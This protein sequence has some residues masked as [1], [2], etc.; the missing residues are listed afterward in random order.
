M[1]ED[2]K[3]LLSMD[4]APSEAERQNDVWDD[5]N[6]CNYSSDGSK[7]LE[8]Y[9]YPGTVHVKD[10]TKVICD[11][12]FAF[13]DYMDEERRLGEEIPEDERVS[14]LDKI[15]L[16]ASVTH[17]GAAAFRECGWMKSIRLP[18]SLR[19]I[20]EDAFFGCWQL[21]SIA[22]PA[23]TLVIG[24]GAFAECFE[25]SKVRL[26]KGLRAIGAEAFYYC[27]SLTEIYLPSSL[28]FIGTDAFMGAKSLKTIYVAPS[29]RS[30]IAAMLP[31]ALVKKIRN[32][33]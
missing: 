18:K 7:L 9:N 28:E 24:D 6:C 19:V 33:K 21:R 31:P 11:E 20:G 2:W 15:F 14:Y 32:L 1:P 23:A 8:A 30:K 16:P 5:E 17:I 4:T 27:D 3:E 25:L 12:A 13:Q 22:L 10:G 26:N 29:S